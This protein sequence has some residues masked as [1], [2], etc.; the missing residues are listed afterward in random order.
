MYS[1]CRLKGLEHWTVLLAAPK[2]IPVWAIHLGGFGLILLGLLDS[3]I[4][5]LPGSMDILTILLAARAERFWFYY[6]MMAT[7][8]S[9][10]GGYITYRIAR[11]Q[12]KESLGKRLSKKRMQRVTKIFEKFGLGAIIV[13]A[14]LPPPTPMV[15]FILAAGAMQYSA[16]K[17]VI[18]FFIGRA[19]R[20]TILAFLAAKYGGA[21]LK[22]IYH[23]GVPLLIAFVALSLATGIY[24]LVQYK[25]K[26]K[27]RKR[28]S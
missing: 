19:V 25:M 15:P 23:L 13:P 17:F 22:E 18:A 8:G 21:L 14:I 5:P 2:K 27:G 7:V 1:A 26:K 6:A 11:K 20:F 28:T 10:L 3:S 24:F 12:G 4:I 9:V 16:K